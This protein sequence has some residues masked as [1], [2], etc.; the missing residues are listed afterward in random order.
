MNHKLQTI[1]Y[2]S[3]DYF[4]ALFAWCSFYIFRK[5]YLEKLKYGKNI[6]IDFTE[7]FFL[8]IIIIPLAWIFLYYISG[9]YYEVYR[10]SRLKEFL[11]TLLISL[12]GVTVLFFLTV[13]DDEIGSY[14][15]YY[16]SYIT[17]FLLHFLPTSILRFILSSKTAKLIHD[18]KIGFETIIIGSGEKALSIYNEIANLN[19][20]IGNKILGYI[21]V[22][23]TNTLQEFLPNLG[24]LIDIKSIIKN[25]NVK[26]VIIATDRND[27]ELVNQLI[28]Q[29]Y[30]QNILVKTIPDVHDYIV[31]KVK[32]TNC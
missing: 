1:K 22:N 20:G 4:S 30:S 8:G 17:L 15:H 32:N 11:H 10:K 24:L 25:N 18:R 21:Q 5:L 13:L 3:A 23:G 14:K 19:T 27:N 28:I 9:Y 26:E 6:D 2:L 31:G 12:F 7:N 16:I 29:F